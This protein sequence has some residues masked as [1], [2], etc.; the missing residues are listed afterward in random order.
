MHC[1]MIVVVKLM[2]ISISSLERLCSAAVDR[3]SS[4]RPASLSP[5]SR[6]RNLEARS[7][8]RAYLL[9]QGFM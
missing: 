5:F 1:E 6:G 9:Q 3:P 2:N 7:K 4:P 8:H